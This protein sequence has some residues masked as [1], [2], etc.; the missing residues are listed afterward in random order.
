MSFIGKIYG[1]FY[2]EVFSGNIDWETD[3]FKVVLLKDTYTPDLLNHKVLNDIDL[4]TNE[5]AGTN[6]TAGGAEL[7]NKAIEYTHA[8]RKV[9]VKADDTEWANSTVTAQ[10]AVL[11]KDTTDG[12]TSTLVKVIDFGENKSSTNGTFKLS[13][14]TSVIELELIDI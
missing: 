12:A 7:D 6:Y 8:T 14:G 10:Y 1:E 3:V 2:K 9:L 13:W 11:Y 4:T 5:A